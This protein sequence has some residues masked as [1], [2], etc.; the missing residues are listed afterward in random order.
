LRRI[1]WRV[2]LAAGLALVL[3]SLSLA[4]CGSSSSDS[5]STAE[6]GAA[7]E[8]GGAAGLAEWKQEAAALADPSTL[9]WPGPE[10]PYAP[11]SGKIAII[12][13]GESDPGCHTLTTGA[14][15]AAKAA[16][17]STTVFDTAFET[18]KAGGFVL[19][20]LQ[21]GYDGIFLGAVNPTLIQSAV[22]GATKA[23]VPIGCAVCVTPKEKQYS[24]IMD[25]TSGG[26]GGAAEAIGVMAQSDGKANAVYFY[27]PQQAIEVART[28][29]FEEEFGKCGE[30]ELSVKEV[31][32]TDLAKPGPPFFNG[33]LQSPEAQSVDWV[34]ASSDAYS[35][36]SMQTAVN[37]GLT[38][39]KFA[40]VAAESKM[41][42]AL[43]EADSPAALSVA[44]SYLYAAWAAVDNIMRRVR[45]AETWD[46]TALPVQLVTREN[47]QQFLGGEG[48]VPPQ[49]LGLIKKFWKGS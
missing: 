22:A 7:N 25:A 20:A 41:T 2:G 16:G 38:N 13:C 47:V 49:G 27:A 34:T 46:A 6:S 39:Y 42:A 23:G 9:D 11:G 32:L 10:T 45:N 17:W 30:C 8:G 19:Q 15:Q 31:P 43:S 4:A 18:N 35:V 1:K 21:E 12:S 14:E 37:R 24:D 44:E 5:S 3:V 28:E 26:A 48:L 36:P 40:G 29:A 33:F